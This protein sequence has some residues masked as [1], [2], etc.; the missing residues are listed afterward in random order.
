[1]I[2][3]S[4]DFEN[5]GVGGLDIQNCIEGLILDT[6]FLYTQA[7]VSTGTT[8][9]FGTR[10]GF[11]G[12]A[13]SAQ[14]IQHIEAN[15]CYVRVD[16]ANYIQWIFGKDSSYCSVKHT[17][18][19]LL[20]GAGAARFNFNFNLT[21]DTNGNNNTL[22][23]Q[24]ED[25]GVAWPRVPSSTTYSPSANPVTS[26]YT[27]N[28]IKFVNHFLYITATGNFTINNPI[29]N[30]N[31]I[32]GERILFFIINASGGNIAVQWGGQFQLRGYTDPNPSGIGGQDLY[33]IIE[34]MFDNVV[35]WRQVTNS[36][37][38]ATM[39]VTSPTYS[40]SPIPA[41]STATWSA[42]FQGV[43]ANDAV[44]ASPANLLSPGAGLTWAA[45]VSAANVVTV[46]V[47][48]CTTAAVTPVAINWRLSLSKP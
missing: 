13:T 6:N 18:W 39:L 12:S 34:F 9:T 5:N 37:A 30:N 38:V 48:N 2:F 17:T 36:H 24:V 35:G 29:T 22:I 7:S 8:N 27:P 3:R 16:A 45:Y 10:F 28:A 15:K 23:P 32:T 25:D 20:S 42:T 1:M 11:V 33:R 26:P 21:N 31:T 4:C 46:V 19:A 44:V 40:V 43:A 41:N 14:T 47:A